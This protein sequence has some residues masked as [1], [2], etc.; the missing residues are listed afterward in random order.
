[1]PT[2]VNFQ[3]L[4]E[5]LLAGWVQ[6]LVDFIPD[7]ACGLLRVGGLANGGNNGQAIGTGADD[8]AS[9]V[10]VDVADGDERFI[11]TLANG[12]DSIEAPFRDGIGFGRGLEYGADAEAVGEL[13]I[14]RLKLVEVLDGIAERTAVFPDG[15]NVAWRTI[16]AADVNSEG[17]RLKG[18]LQV[19]VDD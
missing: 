15:A 18:H 6:G 7:F 14:L 11:G 16:A 9:V 13:R 10:G 4:E 17:T 3:G 12:S 1:M 8:V 2:G 5:S 19:V